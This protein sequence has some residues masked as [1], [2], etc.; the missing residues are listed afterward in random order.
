MVLIDTGA[1]ISTITRDFCEQHGYDIHPKKQMLHL[2]GMGGL[3]IPYLG[4]IEAIIRIAPIEHYEECVPMLVLKS[5]SP[6]SLWVTVQLGT[7]VLDQAMAKI[8][9][10]LPHAT[11]TWHQ[12]YMSSV[13]TASAASTIEQGCQKT[14]LIDTPLVTMKSIVILPL[15]A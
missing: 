8:V 2:I 7:M 6:F 1:Q 14:S 15:V 10:E 3:S 11:S 4:Y 9:E 13:V 12:T 5:F